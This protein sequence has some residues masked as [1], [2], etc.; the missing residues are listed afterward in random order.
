[1]RGSWR[2][3]VGALLMVLVVIAVIVVVTRDDSGGDSSNDDSTV[4]ARPAA[5][6][7]QRWLAVSDIHFNPFAGG[8]T[9]D[10][11][12]QLAKSSPGQWAP[13]LAKL[14]HQPSQYGD[15]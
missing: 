14:Q 10:D 3:G 1:M 6:A 11:V 9:T 2:L 12:N 4:T 13:I 8:A 7:S 5:V 15:D